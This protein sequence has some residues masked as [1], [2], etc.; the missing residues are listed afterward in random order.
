MALAKE[1]P[2]LEGV[3]EL[4]ASELAQ[5]M[6]KFQQRCVHVDPITNQTLYGD[7]MK[8]KVGGCLRM[9]HRQ[10]SPLPHTP[11]D[12]EDCADP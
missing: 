8:K 1:A 11:R 9:D 5:G 2:A 12:D 6:A 4:L 10:P 7:S 3:Q